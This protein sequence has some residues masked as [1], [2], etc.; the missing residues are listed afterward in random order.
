M[1]RLKHAAR[2]ALLLAVAACTS[3]GASPLAPG[4]PAA[5]ISDA[6]HSGEVP[7]FYFLPPMVPQPVYAGTFDAA[8]SPRVEICV[9]SGMSCG[10]VIATYTTSSGPGGEVVQVSAAEELY[11]VHWH[12]NLF[13]L[14]VT[15][16][17]RISVY[18]GTFLLGFA[19]VD[20]VSSGK[21]LKNVDTGQFIPL[22]DDRTLPIKFR[23]ETGI[24]QQVLVTPAADTINVGET[25]QFTA[26][27][28]DLHGN[29]ITGPTVVWSSSDTTVATIDQA[30]LATGVAPGTVTITADIGYVSG[31]ASLT[32]EEPNQPP[33]AFADTFDAIGNFTTPVAA[34]GVLG[35]DT[36]PDLDVLAVAVPGTFAT[37]QGGTVTLNADGSFTYLSPAGFTGTDSFTYVASDGLATSGT[38]TV[39]INVPNRVWYVSNAGA[40][41]GDGR[42]ASPFTTLAGAEAASAAGE[43]IFVLHGDGTTTGYDQGITL[44][45]GQS[46]TGQGI[47]AHFTATV[48]G[49]TV[50]LLVAGSAP[51][52]TRTT[53][54]PT[55]QLASGNTVQ[56]LNA[57]STAGAGVAGSEFGTF[58][59]AAL[60][61]DA[62]GGP[63][64]DLSSGTAAA[65]LIR[66]SS[67]GSS[68]AGLNLTG[69][70][71]SFAVT[72]DGATAGSG[73]SIQGAAGAAVSLSG[74]AAVQLEL[75]T[76][77]PTVTG[78]IA[79]DH[80]G[81]VVI[82]RSTIDYQNTAPAGAF[83]VRLANTSTNGSLVLDGTT[84]RNKL[85]GTTAVSISAMG[86][87]VIGFTVRDSDTGDAF[88]SEFTNLF[89]SAI[90]VGAGDNLGSTAHVTATVRDSRFVNAAPNGTNTLELTV[91]QNATLDYH[92]RNNL[93]DNV[94][95]A[96]AIAG[97]INLNAVGSG[98][99]GSTTAA[100]SIVGNTIRNIGAGS[101]A[102][103]YIGIRAAIDNSVT[104][105]N[106][107][108]VI[109]GNTLEN[110]W[111]QGILVSGRGSANDVNVRIA[112]NVVGTP[113]APVARS[114][115]RGVEIE[116]QSN[117]AMKVEV[118]NNPS[119]VNFSSSGSN[120]ALHLR[121]TA[122]TSFIGATV[123]GNTIANTNSS[124]TAGRFRA[125]TLSGTT[126]NACLDL[127]T[128]VLDEASKL[129]EVIHASSGTFSLNFGLNVGTLATTGT[130]TTVGSCPT[131][132]L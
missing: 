50:V 34:P 120:S 104:G 54:G 65:T 109:E 107:R 21:E 66:A 121:S 131:P 129:Y 64:V 102:L 87:S 35:N 31:T 99:L 71:G 72:G 84:V 112:N 53:A 4:D 44:K 103:G 78:V 43:T 6:A 24:V 17:Y 105:I 26:T 125:E 90:L 85:D 89:G 33:V 2:T 122:S 39:T 94:A 62:T 86:S 76:I 40:A 119:I 41:P 20:V 116:A 67:S 22:V 23:I 124:I 96:S 110:I 56:G 12:T 123:V 16:T 46:L 83:A 88:P 42:D 18:S 38:A 127:R 25:A 5:V 51:N 91:A 128:N 13:N 126:A 14:D 111:R 30:G 58:T 7:G 92:I 74:S 68:G 9:L 19:D 101:T 52:L 60:R 81:A 75:M 8:L 93:F 115:R 77:L 57:A 10:T 95:K 49:Q 70:G 28:I 108:L 79:T 47:S 59:A 3:D 48:N 114:N 132:S 63:A 117:S 82:E 32:V 55:I 113:A 98:R 1:V 15:K 45:N 61:V 11:K 97:V 29:P 106:H 100:D 36:D 37:A 27:L 130:I 118:L 80:S 69:V 73:G